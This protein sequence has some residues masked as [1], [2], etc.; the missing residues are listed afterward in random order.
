MSTNKIGGAEITKG[1]AMSL[2]GSGS[3]WRGVGGD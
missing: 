1:E 2:G 3:Q